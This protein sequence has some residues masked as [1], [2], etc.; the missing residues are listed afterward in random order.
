[1]CMYVLSTSSDGAI[2]L[3]GCE[4]GKYAYLPAV[5]VSGC[6][7]VWGSVIIIFVLT[8]FDVS[9]SCYI[10]VHVPGAKFLLTLCRA[11]S[12]SVWS[13]CEHRHE[14]RQSMCV[15]LRGM[16]EKERE[17]EGGRER[18]RERERGGREREG[19]R[20]REGGRERES[21]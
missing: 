14:R 8:T 20:G 12:R 16:E 4:N 6:Q 3:D 15:C 21:E 5:W 2:A 11:Y 19:G 17:R 13:R 9:L 7:L 1:M 18:E 10:H